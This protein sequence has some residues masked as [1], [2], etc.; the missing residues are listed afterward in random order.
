[1]QVKN[2]KGIS[3]EWGEIRA[4][5][6]KGNSPMAIRFSNLDSLVASV[7]Y[8]TM[9]YYGNEATECGKSNP[10]SLLY[11]VVRLIGDPIPANQLDQF[12]KDNPVT[13]D[14]EGIHITSSSIQEDPEE[15]VTRFLRYAFDAVMHSGNMEYNDSIVISYPDAF[16]E[17]QR[18]ELISIASDIY[19]RKVKTY[20]ASVASCMNL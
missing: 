18:A 15:I 16:S 8:G 13:F 9:E 17:D 1:M 7:F 14:S 6:W 12:L 10:F 19:M 20:P 11:N 5:I 4:S 2:V 3:V